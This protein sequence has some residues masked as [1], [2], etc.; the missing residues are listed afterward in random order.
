MREEKRAAAMAGSERARR[1]ECR[2]FASWFEDSCRRTRS[3]RRGRVMRDA[4]GA[5]LRNL[6]VQCR[7][8]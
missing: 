6:L 3:M 2:S 8:Q 1:R 5:L 7:S 4:G